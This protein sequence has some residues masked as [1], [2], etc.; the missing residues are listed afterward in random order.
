MN[1]IDLTSFMESYTEKSEKNYISE[2]DALRPDL[3]SM[4]IFDKLLIGAASAEDPYFALCKEHNVVGQ[5]FM[6]PKEWLP[7]AESV[8]SVFFSYTDR[9]IKSNIVKSDRPS[10]EWLHARYE[11]QDFIRH[12]MLGL[13]DELE[14]NGHSAVVPLADPRFESVRKQEE[15]KCAGR[16]FTSNWSERHIAFGCGLGTFGLS[17]GIITKYG[18]AG[19]LGS[20]VTALKLH[21]TGR[22]YTNVYEYCSMC[23]ACAKRCPAG[24]IQMSEGKNHAVCSELINQT[25]IKFPPR[26]G[27]GKCQTGVPCQSR[28]PKQ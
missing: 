13:K 18:T 15:G 4:R 26:L 5:H 3:I 7:D 6:A 2:R 17:A 23:G 20:I 22:S 16:T 27:C 9:V 1:L 28:I 12:V 19:R 25:K 11:G 10:D 24:A 21:P 8:I 14:R